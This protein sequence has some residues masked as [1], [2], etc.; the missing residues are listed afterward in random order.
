MSTTQV[1][2]NVTNHFLNKVGEGDDNPVP[3]NLALRYFFLSQV[4]SMGCS[5]GDAS[6]CGDFRHLS[7][8]AKT[9]P[10]NPV[11]L[12]YRIRPIS[13]LVSILVDLFVRCRLVMWESA[14]H[15]KPL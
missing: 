13:D 6:L 7:E 1:E 12:T 11:P 14:V 2:G 5:G 3:S 8:Y 9:A 15:S 10:L 4:F